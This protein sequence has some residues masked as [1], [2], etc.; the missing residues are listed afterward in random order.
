MAL[1]TPISLTLAFIGLVL[2][3]L[4]NIPL[5]GYETVTIFQNDFNATEWHWFYR[6]MPFRIPKPGSTCDPY[7]FKVGDSFSGNYSF[8]EWKIDSIVKPTAGDLQY[9]IPAYHLPP[10]ISSSSSSMETSY[11]GISTLSSS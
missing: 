9:L 5:T 6:F 4:V 2:L 7:I 3:T 11:L 8:F 10:V 1:V